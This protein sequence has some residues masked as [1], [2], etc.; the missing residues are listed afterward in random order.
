[1]RTKLYSAIAA[2]LAVALG[3][4]LIYLYAAGRI[5]ALTAL[6]A[7]LAMAFVMIVLAALADLAAED[8]NRARSRHPAHRP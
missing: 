8:R 7:V 1:M 5:E 2:F 3:L 6:V 4:G